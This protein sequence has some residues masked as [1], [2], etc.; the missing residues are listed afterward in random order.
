MYAYRYMPSTSRLSDKGE[1]R[2]A[3]GPATQASRDLSHFDFTG[4]NPAIRLHSPSWQLNTALKPVR[5]LKRSS[6]GNRQVLR[7]TRWG[8][9]TYPDRPLQGQGPTGT[10]WKIQVEVQNSRIFTLIMQL[11]SWHSMGFVPQDEI[12]KEIKK[13]GPRWRVEELGP[14]TAD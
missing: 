3:A 11:G 2:Q 7:G 5:F 6:K 12:V 14:E 1:G 10:S 13:K 4:Q 8:T 9:G